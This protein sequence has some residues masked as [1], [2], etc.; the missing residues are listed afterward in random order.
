MSSPAATILIVDDESQNRKLLDTLLRPE[1]YLTLTAA[2]GEDALTSIEKNAPDLILLDIMM[3]G[4]DGYEVAAILKAN[5]A[6]ASIP[7]IMVTAHSD[8]SARLAGLSAGAEEFLTKPVDRAE[9][10]LRVRNLLRLK[11][12]SDLESYSLILEQ[13]VR[14][15]TAELQSFRA[16]MDATLDAIMLIDRDTMRF[17]EVNATACSMLG[18]TREELFKMSPMEIGGVPRAQLEKEYDAIIAGHCADELT[19]G[20]ARHKDGTTLQMEVRRH[21]H[22]SGDNWII[23]GLLRDITERK[24]AEKLLHN[25]ARLR[26]SEAAKQVAILNALPAYI[27]LLDTQGAIISVNEAW[28]HF[29]SAKAIQ[30][31]GYGIGLN[32]LEICDAATGE[33]A[34]GARQVAAGIRSVLD[35]E[36]KSFSIEYPCHSSTEQF[37]FLLMV[38][39]LAEDKSHSAV[40]MHLDVTAQRRAEQSL[41][42]SEL[43]F[44]QMAEN[45]RDVFFLVDATNNRILYISPAYQEIWGRSE[46]PQ[47]KS[48]LDVIHPDDQASTYAKSKGRV[49][50]EKID[51]EYRIVR[52]DGSIRWIESRGFPVCD[53][54]GKI[55]RI[56]GVARDVTDSK[57]AAQELHESER[58]FRDLLQNVE[59]ISLMLDCDAHITYCNE[60]LLRLTGWQYEEVIGGNWFDIFAPPELDDLESDFAAHLANTAEAWHRENEILTRSGERRLVRWNNSVLRS[61]NGEVTGIASIGEDITEQKR[62]EIKIR[63][64]NRVYAVLS[65]INTLIVRVHDRDELFKEACRIAVEVGAFKMAWIGVIDPQ[66]QDGDVVAMHGGEDGYADKSRLTMRDDTP[67][68][69]RPACRALRQSRPVICN[70]IASE[71]SM[72]LTRNELLSGGR[73]SLGCFPLTVAGSPYGVLALFAGEPDFFD[74]EEMPLLLE[75]AD[76]I[77]FALDHIGKEEKLNYLA[78]YDVLTGL[79]NR[80]LFLERVGQYMRAA[81]ANGRRLALFLI[82]LERFKNINDSLGRAAGDMLLKQVADWLAKNLGDVNLLARVGPDHFAVV[83]PELKEEGDMVRLL[84]GLMRAFLDHPFRLNDGVFRVSIKA[85]VALFPEDGTIA[86]TLFRNAEAALK[87]AK[88]SGERYLFYTQKMTATVAGKL[89]L[90]S[91]LCQAIERNEFVLHYQPKVCVVSGLLSGA[92]ALIR[93]NDP[94]TGLVPP[95]RFIPVLEETGLIYEVG[96]WALRQ[97]I[98]DYLRWRAAGLPVVRIAV[99]VSPLQLRN[100]GFLDEIQQ[101]IGI[102][103]YAAEGLELEI[104]ESV[105][106]AD[107]AHSATTLRAIRAMGVSIAIDD[108]GTGF[109]SLN[110][111]SKLPV[112]TLK[113]DRSFVIDMNTTPEGLALVATIINLAH[114]LKLKVVAEGVEIEEQVQLLRMLRCEQM[115]GFLFGKPVPA[116]EFEAR[117]LA[118]AAK[119]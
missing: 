7:I 27:A 67:D 26:L 52:P 47:G 106:M 41:L 4:I 116:D 107:V 51:F 108:F 87:N 86:D 10:W 39:P 29:E 33:G 66:T 96:R 64:L 114:S 45:I 70:D 25:L 113:I 34:F 19:E 59:L 1:G 49:S 50:A 101:V 60:H 32:Y 109:S 65:G 20:Q 78:Y 118:P 93:W 9:L 31:P 91:Q 105:V 36:A 85:G 8:R 58:R 111:L 103:P 90:E 24:E 3:P 76:D 89:T 40:V 119:L 56:A 28:R 68:S 37:W 35:G 73:K 115:Q 81:A 80:S 74:D 77:S 79:A 17:V 5:P 98:D 82:D 69:D 43:R 97:A 102:D 72:L 62:A 110:Y 95:G 18:Y 57:Q 61:A 48:W 15:R 21:A 53:D 38:T 63:R 44:R 112:D 16:A 71:P 23:V 94:R 13:T 46:S 42:A 83:L 100:R 117:F 99:N 11:K 2:N 104:T 14:R 54:S 12:F 55:V 84:E 30:G 92:E 88:A 22:R 75:L 6:T